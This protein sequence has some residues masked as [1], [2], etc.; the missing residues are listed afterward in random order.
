VR[1]CALVESV[2]LFFI[3]FYVS[4]DCSL[5]FDSSVFSLSLTFIYRILY[6]LQFEISRMRNIVTIT[7]M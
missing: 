3:M 2:L 5:L 4:L 1:N 6:N 7:N